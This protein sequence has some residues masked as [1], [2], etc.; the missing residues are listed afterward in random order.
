MQACIFEVGMG[1]GMCY[2]IKRSAIEAG[3]P[4][5]WQPVQTLYKASRVLDAWIRV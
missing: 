3:S 4:L 5:L 1:D 2:S